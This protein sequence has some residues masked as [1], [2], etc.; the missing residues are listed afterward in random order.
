MGIVVRR[1]F[2][3]YSYTLSNL[4][5]TH[6]ISGG[7]G[8]AVWN[9]QIDLDQF[10]PGDS[11][12]LTEA[13]IFRLKQ[14]IIEQSLEPQRLEEL[15]KSKKVDRKELNSTDLLELM[16]LMRSTEKISVVLGPIFPCEIISRQE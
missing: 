10:L 9:D 6:I 14:N 13:Q 11:P 12:M 16:E 5:G 1:F 4:V 3:E 2:A 8:Y 15:K 7:N